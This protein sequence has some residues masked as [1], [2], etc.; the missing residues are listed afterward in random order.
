VFS[1]SSRVSRAGSL[2][3]VAAT[4]LISSIPESGRPR[5]GG[6]QAPW[7]GHAPGG[8]VGFSDESVVDGVVVDAPQGGDER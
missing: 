1:C 7:F 4:L 2:P 5:R 3:V 8:V 6:G